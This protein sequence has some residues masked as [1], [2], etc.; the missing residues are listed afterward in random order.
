MAYP[1]V[2]MLHR[3]EDSRAVLVRW[4]VLIET[5]NL[6]EKSGFSNNAYLSYWFHGR[7]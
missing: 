3:C 5:L 7:W 1:F 2:I 4:T 6:C